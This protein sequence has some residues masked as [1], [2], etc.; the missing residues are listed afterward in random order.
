MQGRGK[1]VNEIPQPGIGKLLTQINDG[2]PIRI[3][4][5]HL[6]ELGKGQF[7]LHFS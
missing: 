4:F 3:F 6:F 5:S 7:G 1:T 2:W